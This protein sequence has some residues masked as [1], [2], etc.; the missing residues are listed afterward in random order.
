MCGIAQI[1]VRPKL[2]D[3]QATCTREFAMSEN[4]QSLSVDRQLKAA[5]EQVNNLLSLEHKLTGQYPKERLQ[6]LVE[7]WFRDNK[8]DVKETWF[9]IQHIE[10]VRYRQTCESHLSRLSGTSIV[11]IRKT[12]VPETFLA[13]TDIQIPSNEKA[14]KEAGLV[15]LLGLLVAASALCLFLLPQ[16]EGI[17]LLGLVILAVGLLRKM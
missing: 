12:C 14:N 16:P 13:G 9:T 5:S 4:E 10:N 15:P 2:I 7:D 11:D 8:Q 6:Q 17:I 1:R 3:A